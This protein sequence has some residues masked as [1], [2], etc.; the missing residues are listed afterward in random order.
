MKK[1]ILKIE[2]MSCSACS[3]GL[4][5]YLNKQDGISAASVNL[6]SSS[7]L[8]EYEDNITIDDLNR[9]VSEAGFKSLGE[10]KIEKSLIKDNTKIYLIIYAILLIFLMYISMSHMLKLPQIPFLN[11]KNYP[12]NYGLSLF[13]LTIPFLVFGFDI[14]KSGYK[15][16]IHKTPNMDTLVT[17][18]VLSSFLYSLYNLVMVFLGNNMY[19][20]NLY[21]EG[22]ATIIFFIKLGRYIDK[23]AKEKT[24][25]AIEGL[26]QI[27]PEYALI[28][29]KDGEKQLT[30]DEVKKG[31]I[32]IC[33]PGMKFAVDG[34]I[35]KGEAHTD[36]SFI[37][38][39]SV[40]SKKAI[41][42]KVLAGSINMDGYIEYKAEKIGKNSTIS[43]MVKL[44]L[45]AQNTK[46]K[47]SLLADKICGYFVPSIMLIA[48]I[49]LI[50]YLI[51]SYPLNIVITRFVS[52]L[53]VACPCAL[54]LATPLACV[55][56]SGVCAKKGLLI[57]SSEVLENAS[58]ID[59]IVFDKTGT[60][61]YGKLKV[62]KI[63]NLSKH[64]NED[65]LKIVGSIENKSS[66]PIATAFTSY[67]KENNLKFDEV[68]D[69][70]NMNGIGVYAKINKKEYYIGN[71]KIFKKFKIENMYSN[72]E[73][74]L[75]KD[76]NSVVYV[77]ENNKVIAIIGVKDIIRD[78]AKKVVTSLQ[79]L[80]IDVI[81][82][83]GDNEKTAKLIAKSVGIKNVKA[84]MLPKEKT[85]IIKKLELENKKVM[86]V[87]DGINDAIALETATIG[88]SVSSA[89]DIAAS[90]SSVIL[91]N[92]NLERLVDLINISKKT[93]KII[94]ENLFWAFF[95]NLLM[96]PIAIGLF[97][98]FG[99]TLN[100]MFASL[101]MTI[102]SLSVVFNSL[103]LRK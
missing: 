79:K 73:D 76:E 41:N 48:I 20:E 19:V 10:Y 66:H 78:N 72:Y 33:K 50:V 32:L 24:N 26:V 7:A 97:T 53:V 71:S 36:E 62:S 60:L 67:I 5:K 40:S 80:G 43:E 35:S 38:G 91:M 46:P 37:T 98:H 4:E 52:V 90:S 95:Y 101:A 64:K 44:V 28:K 70:K 74:D 23:Q 25:T 31:D 1:I 54:G 8:I 103:R 88:V 75:V 87:G 2:G 63:I 59:T 22:T 81:M 92:D 99:L 3:N 27:T 17:L 77:I 30:I 21:F 16:L 57:K 13:I 65:I 18:G 11:M 61:T 42:D 14:F 89:T 51:L 39:E 47:I 68:N 29:T 15:N 58:K 93:F 83:S 6:V 84:N 100:P 69:F 102:S 85:D 55:I 12:T 96:I 49:T 82:L 9:F 56:S 45:E 86:M 34:I 94:K